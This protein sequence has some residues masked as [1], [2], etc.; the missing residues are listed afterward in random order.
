MNDFRLRLRG[1]IQDR[2]Q[3]VLD[4]KINCIPLPFKRFREDWPGIE[5][6]RIYLIS[7]GTKSAKSMIT[8]Y[9]FVINTIMYCYHH[10]EMIRPKILYFPL[11]ES[12]EAITLK[13]MCFFLSYITGGNTLISP[14]DLLST[15]ETK[16]LPQEVLDLL[17]SPKFN[18]L[19]DLF[20]SIVEFY[21]EFNRIGIYKVIDNYVKSNGTIYTK[22]DKRIVKDDF[23]NVLG[24]EEY[25]AFDY[26]VPNNPEQYVICIIDHLSLLSPIKGEDL[27]LS[28][29]NFAVDCVKFRDRYKVTFACVQQQNLEST[30]L[31]AFKANKILP[32]VAG[33]ADCKDMGKAANMMLGI[34]NPHYFELPDYKGYD[35]TVLKGMA[36]FLQVTINRNGI[37]NGICP[38]LFIPE[39]S[40]FQ[41][42]PLSTD[43]SAM[44]KIY[45]Y[46]KTYKNRP[47]TNFMMFNKYLHK[48]FGK[49]RRNK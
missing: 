37:S 39:S 28:I 19:M 27:R 47:K 43:R 11:E 2:R 45:D 35:I 22:R 8:N 14:T 49:D 21:N 25:D 34:L 20:D 13:V 33:L 7:G 15:N 1:K 18:E 26:Y 9:L 31:E 24:E 10:P 32:T 44:S 3:R 4:G 38:M 36:R 48:I 46:V 30:G 12:R 17:D 40:S 41:E 6:E 29:S 16:P 23:G 42:L 5:Q